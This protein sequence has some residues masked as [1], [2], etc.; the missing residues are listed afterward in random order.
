[1]NEP[2]IPHESRLEARL[3]ELEMLTTHLQRTLGD[4]DQ[5]ILAQQKRIEGLERELARLGNSLSAVAGSIAD[6]RDP[7]EEKPPHY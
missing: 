1:M 6:V 7:A 5:V 3:I 4:L 2:E